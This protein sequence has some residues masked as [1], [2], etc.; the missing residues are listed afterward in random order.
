MTV[1]VLL[2]ARARDLAGS[3]RITLTLPDRAAVKELRSALQQAVPALR[4]LAANLFIAIGN[5][6]ARDGDVVPAN[7]TIACFPPVS[8]G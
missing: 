4:P 2:F 7:A 6:Y 5:D 1:E 3:E 8:G